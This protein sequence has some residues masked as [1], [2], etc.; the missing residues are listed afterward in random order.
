MSV[1]SA[2]TEYFGGI[3]YNPSFYQQPTGISLA[4]GTANYVSRVGT[5]TSVATS[6]N[7]SGSVLTNTISDTTSGSGTLTINPNTTNI[8]GDVNFSDNSTPSSVNIA[9]TYGLQV[10]TITPNTGTTISVSADTTNIVGGTAINIATSG[11]LGTCNLINLYNQ[12]TGSGTGSGTPANYV[13]A[14]TN[15]SYNQMTAGYGTNM[16][17]NQIDSQNV[18]GTYANIIKARNGDNSMVATS[19]ANNIIGFKNSISSNITTPLIP[20][21]GYIFLQALTGISNYIGQLSPLVSGTFNVIDAATSQTLLTLNDTYVKLQAPNISGTMDII[22]NYMRI[23]GVTSGIGQLYF[24]SAVPF[25]TINF[26]NTNL[27]LLNTDIVS[28]Q[29]ATN[30]SG[31]SIGIS[32]L[33]SCVGDLLF[34]LYKQTSSSFFNGSGFRF[35]RENAT[36]NFLFQTKNVSSGG[37]GTNTTIQTITFDGA[38]ETFTAPT[39]NK[40]ASTAFNVTDGTLNHLAITPTLTTLTNTSNTMSAVNSNIISTTGTVT[41]SSNQIIANGTA[42]YPNANNLISATGYGGYNTISALNQAGNGYNT[43]QAWSENLIS[44][45]SSTGTNVIQSTG[46]SGTN[47]IS[48]S[49]NSINGPTTFNDYISVASAVTIK[50]ST[51]INVVNAT[52]HATYNASS[53][54]LMSLST[55]Y[56]FNTAP[57]STV[58]VQSPQCVTSSFGTQLQ[59]GIAFPV[60]VI[61]MGYYIGSDAGTISTSPVNL[62]IQVVQFSSTIIATSGSLAFTSG[63]ASNYNG[64]FTSPTASTAGNA[65]GCQINLTTSVT[66]N[67]KKFIVVIFFAQ[68]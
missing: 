7:F 2:P 55:S 27:Q 43:I 51:G 14:S 53:V 38:T 12:I 57:I 52:T 1:E 11:A 46:T 37:I 64:K 19:G 56:I 5:A 18:T 26:Q 29:D 61:P 23:D 50:N 13:L 39:Q 44:T 67:N 59:A 9:N 4:Y 32:V 63:S 62:T 22:T 49:A 3:Y 58:Y 68:W 25:N 33:S 41:G 28:T 31:R 48:S 30:T 16:G 10:N 66:T 65:Y 45:T 47:S 60:N 34:S 21:N 36:S 20:A 6:T 8:N 15:G 35:V 40:V 54:S 24:G 17:Y 42:T